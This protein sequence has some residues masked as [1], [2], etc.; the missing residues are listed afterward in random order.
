MELR[1]KKMLGNRIRELRRAFGYTQTELG[2]KIGETKQT[3]YKYESGI[4]SNVP[5]DKVEA[6]AAALETTPAYL[7]GWTDDPHDSSH[8][9]ADPDRQYLLNR[10]RKA[11]VQDIAKL[12]KLL[13]VI[14]DETDSK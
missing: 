7:M 11:S 13:E 14:D 6:L 10:I 8:Q 12:K 5:S 2:D 9:F 3:I 1:Y 4:V